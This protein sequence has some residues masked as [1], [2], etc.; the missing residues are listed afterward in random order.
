MER[1]MAGKQ[2]AH[3]ACGA[4]EAEL[5]GEP[6][7]QCYCHCTDCRDWLGAPV[8][9]ATIWPNAQVR[10]TKGGENVVTYKRTGKS[11]RKSCKSCGGAV[12]IEH[13]GLGVFDVLASNIK[14]FQFAPAFHIFYGER[15]IDMKDG[16]A[17]FIK[18]P[19]PMGGDGA[20]MA[21]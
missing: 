21:E 14:G 3:C 4:V 13:P 7:L 2:K 12:L 17:K 18:M 20:T 15:M 19:E 8:H 11:H 5:T 6:V 10:Y 16:L 1:K 9:A